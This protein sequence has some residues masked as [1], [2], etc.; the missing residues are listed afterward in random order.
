[1]SQRRKLLDMSQE[2]RSELGFTVLGPA[3]RLE[4]RR[5]AEGL[6]QPGFDRRLKSPWRDGGEFI[7][8]TVDR[9]PSVAS[10][11]DGRYFLRVGDTCQPILGDDVLR[12]ANERTGRPWES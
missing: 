3:N 1:M 9:S 12:L 10:T 5:Y 2:A 11:R 8:L 7:A 6:L 4:K